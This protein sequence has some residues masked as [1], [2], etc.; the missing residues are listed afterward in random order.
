MDLDYGHEIE[1][2]L[3]KSELERF[4]SA[5]KEMFLELVH[6]RRTDR[7][8]LFFSIRDK[9]TAD[10]LYGAVRRYEKNKNRAESRKKNMSSLS[11]GIFEKEDIDLIYQAQQGL[12]YYT[13]EPL[14]HNPKNYSIDHV[15]P[16][17]YGGSSW[18]SN[19]VLATIDINREKYI[20]ARKEIFSFLKKKNGKEW[21]DEQR[22]FC[23]NVDR[24]RRTIDKNRRLAV[25]EKLSA[26]LD[27]LIV[28]FPGIEIKYGIKGDDVVLSV[29]ATIIQFFPGFIRHK[30][31]P[32]SY[33]YIAALVGAITGAEISKSVHNKSL[34]FDANGGS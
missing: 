14:T 10:T 1:G 15:V 32:Y 2:V 11:A 5:L 21:M 19:L 18:P 13:R 33:Q 3:E 34:R 7:T 6:I 30:E 12:C 4:P 22:V 28:A 29:D 17:T 9:E 23:R 25:S 20:Y 27:M 24:K 26:V 8:H 31:R 16:V